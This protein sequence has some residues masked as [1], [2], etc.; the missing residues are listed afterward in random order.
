MVAVPP[1]DSDGFPTDLVMPGK[2]RR[3]VYTNQRPAATLWYHDHAMDSTGRNLFMG[4]AGLYIVED[5][6]ERKLPL[7]RDRHDIPLI[8]QNRLF[9]QDGVLQFVPDFLHGAFAD[10]VLVNGAPWPRLEVAARRYRFRILNASNATAFRLAL[11]SGR[12]F[13]QIGTD[14]GLLASPINITEIPLAMAERV[15]VIVD[16]SVY[17]TGTQIFLTDLNRQKA[18]IVRFDVLRRE[19]DDTV[20]PQR[21]SEVPLIS[22][23]S[24][25][26]TRTLLF[27]RGSEERWAINL[28]EFDADR[29]IAEPHFGDVEVWRVLNHTFLQGVSIVHPVHLHLVNFQ[30]L[31]RNGKPP[32]AHERGW[33]DTVAL[34]S[35]D[36]VK[37]I[38]KF[39][40][41]RGRYL[42]HCH[43]LEHED[44][45]MMARF[46]VV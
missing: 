28:K 27:T 1:P 34:E 9:A 3:Y 37:L 23:D 46:D 19:P 11:S 18:G 2:S 39:D 33:K 24:A 44:R 43:N 6:M 12:P 17:P 7:P 45:G 35:G 31:E 22:K 5:P 38:I 10:T 15:E 26:R 20:I 25:V 29:P 4:L 14:G 42:L 21:L 30:I 41:Y 8:I 40:G 32:L 16:F 36:E 13:T